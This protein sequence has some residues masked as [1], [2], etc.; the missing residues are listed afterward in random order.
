MIHQLEVFHIINSGHRIQ[1]REIQVRVRIQEL[2]HFENR[3]R[4]NPHICIIIVDRRVWMR[5]V[6]SARN[7]F[8]R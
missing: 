1:E 5:L 6:D 2:G 7:I 4:A 3:G 8:A